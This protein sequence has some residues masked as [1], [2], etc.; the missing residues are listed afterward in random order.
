MRLR[1]LLIA[2]ISCLLCLAALSAQPQAAKKA[3]SSL[4][5]GWNAYKSADYSAALDAAR[6]AQREDPGNPSVLEL[7]GRTNLAMG[8]PRMA[9][10]ALNILCRKRG[11]VQDYRL[12]ALADTMAGRAKPAAAALQKAEAG[13]DPT[14]EGLYALAWD[15]PTAKGRLALLE[16]IAKDFPKASPALKAEIDFWKGHAGATLREPAKALPDGGVEIKLKTLFNMEWVVCKTGSGKEIWL[17]VDTAARHTVVSQ[18]TAKTLGL[19]PVQA[20]YKVPGAY[21]EEPAPRYS[22]LDTLDLG[23]YKISNVPVTIV[24]DEAGTLNVRAGRNVLK[25]ILGMDILKGLKIRFNRHKNVLSLFPASAPMSL[26]MDG[27][28]DKWHEVPAYLVYGQ[29]LVP[30]SLGN[31]HKL[32][33]LFDT[34]CSFVLAQADAL[35]GSGVQ[36]TSRTMIDLSAGPQEVIPDEMGGSAKD[37]RDLMRSQILGW[38]EEVLPMVGATRTVP[39]DTDVTLGNMTFKIR[40]LPVYPQP[41]GGEVPISVVVGRK[42]TDFFAVAMDLSTGKL[43]IKQVLF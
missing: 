2:A 16:K 43:Y 40:D 9:L 39:K 3:A 14:P 36:A 1:T 8:Q 22:L 32:L 25:G 42:I 27:K 28:A 35:N 4:E 34:G 5:K 17:M 13:K 10:G 21:P 33:A 38:L 6:T 11:T 20:A 18:A 12:L 29:I 31:K 30:S 41:L 37:K 24:K 15:K 19:Q 23:S 7:W 26:L